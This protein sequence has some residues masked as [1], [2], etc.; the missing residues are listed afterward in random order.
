[1]QTH[2]PVQI[3]TTISFAYQNEELTGKVKHCILQSRGY[4]LGI[5][6]QAEYRWSPAQSRSGGPSV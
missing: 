2:R 5:E 6:F 1:M 4:L 3:G